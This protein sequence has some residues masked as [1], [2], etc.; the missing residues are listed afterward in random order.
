MAAEIIDGQKIDV[1]IK[2]RYPQLEFDSLRM[3]FGE[4]YVIDLEEIDGSITIYQ[5]TIG[6]MIRVGENKFHIT[7]NF[8]TTN[9][10]ACRL[11]LHQMGKDWNV[12]SDFELFCLLYHNIDPEVSKLIFGDLDWSKFK[13]AQKTDTEGNITWFL[14]NQEQNIIINESVYQ[15]FHQYLQRVFNIFPEEKFTRDPMLK[16]WWI[17]QEV[18]R[19][20]REESKPSSESSSIQPIISALVNHPGFKYKLK[21]LKDVGVCEFYDSVKRLQIYEQSTAVLKGMYSGMIS[22]KDIDPDSYNFM[23]AI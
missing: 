6:D 2:Q 12:V 13:I 17:D 18:R 22:S 19:T 8:L 9:T 4:P 21:E 1:K 7:L 16:Q 11:M 3:Y 15:H 20:E 10:T 5:P 23:K 14:V